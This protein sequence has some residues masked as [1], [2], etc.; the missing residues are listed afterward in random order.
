M[1]KGFAAGV[2]VN[3][4]SDSP[5]DAASGYTTAAVP[6]PNQPSFYYP[7]HT[8]TDLNFSYTRAKLIYRLNIYNVTDEVYYNGGGSRTSTNVAT[9]LNISASVTYKF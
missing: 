2:G 9:P 7:A 4:M 8:V 1:L 3:Y 6:V 5:G